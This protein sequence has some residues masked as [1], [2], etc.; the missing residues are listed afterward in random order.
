[1]SDFAELQ[2]RFQGFVMSGGTAMRAAIVG[3]DL[4]PADER[5]AVYFDAYRLRLLGIL[6]TEFPGVRA[7]LTAD[8]FRATGLSYLDACPS[9]YPSVRWFASHFADHI[10]TVQDELGLP[11]VGELAHFEWARGRAFDA[12]DAPV[13][14]PAALAALPPDQWPSLRITMTAS[15]N[16]VVFE[17][18]TDDL[19]RAINKGEPVPAAQRRE[20]AATCCVW[21]RDLTV[22]WR[23]MDAAETTAF[24][25][26]DTGRDF[27][28]VCGELCELRDESEVPALAAGWLSGWISEGLVAGTR[29]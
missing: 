26:F 14:T 28:Q 4:A 27:A 21:R 2:Q 1:M 16:R 29:S 8:Q 9:A 11:H 17:W 23:V 7:S 6:E 24:A 20:V 19:W 15:A 25:G 12:V 13:L 22:Y 18:N 5:L 10:E 3:D